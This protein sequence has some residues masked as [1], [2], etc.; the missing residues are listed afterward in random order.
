MLKLLQNLRLR[1]KLLQLLIQVIY[2]LLQLRCFVLGLLRKNLNLLTPLLDRVY[3]REHSWLESL[4]ILLD[5]LQGE[6]R[7]DQVQQSTLRVV[8]TDLESDQSI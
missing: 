5:W 7:I 3:V 1:R 4:W 6:R 2:F 8:V